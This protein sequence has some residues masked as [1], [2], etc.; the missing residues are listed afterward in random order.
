MYFCWIFYFPLSDDYGMEEADYHHMP[1]IAH[2]DN[3]ISS[4]DDSAIIK[5]EIFD[6][7]Y[8]EMHQM[9]V[10]SAGDYEQTFLNGVESSGLLDLKA[11]SD[12]SLTQEEITM[13]LKDSVMEEVPVETVEPELPEQSSTVSATTITTNS[14]HTI[15]NTTVDS[16]PTSALSSTA[17]G[18]SIQASLVNAP[19]ILPTLSQPLVNINNLNAATVLGSNAPVLTTPVFLAQGAPGPA[20]QTN[21]IITTHLA[22]LVPSPDG[23]GYILHLGLNPSAPTSTIPTA[24]TSCVSSSGQVSNNNNT[25]STSPTNVPMSG[26]ASA[27][28]MSPPQTC[29]TGGNHSAL[30]S[31]TST[32]DIHTTTAGVGAGQVKAPAKNS[33]PLGV[34][35]N[36]LNITITPATSS[37]AG[38]LQKISPTLKE[39]ESSLS[40]SSSTSANSSPDMGSPARIN[41]QVSPMQIVESKEGS[42]SPPIEEKLICANNTVITTSPPPPM[43]VVSQCINTVNSVEGSSAL[44][45]TTGAPLAINGNAT[46]IEMSA[47]A[48]L[49]DNSRQVL[50]QHLAA[51]QQQQQVQLI[52]QQPPR[53][54][55]KRRNSKELRELME[56]EQIA[57]KPG[58]DT[59]RFVICSDGPMNCAL[60]GYNTSSYSSFK[61]H[62]ICSHPCWRIT[63]KLSRN[64][65]LVEKSVKVSVPVAN[66]SVPNPVPAVPIQQ[67]VQSKKNKKDTNGK[68]T[69]EKAS[70]NDNDSTKREETGKS[71][72]NKQRKEATTCNYGNDISLDTQVVE[73][74]RRIYKCTRCL[75]LFVSEETTVNHIIDVH[76]VKKPYTCIEVSND[77]GKSFS[78]I[79]R[80]PQKNCSF[81]CESISG[82]EKHK[83]EVHTQQAVYR[84]QICGYSAD[85]TKAVNEHAVKIHRQQVMMYGLSD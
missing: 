21:S 56:L 64:R 70:K 2:M 57:S 52:Q 38:I 36:N 7:A 18:I 78:T 58:G 44:G 55:S 17:N 84:C 80:C 9:L 45:I 82:L 26:G 50:E 65:L 81:S 53:S 29:I 79:Y 43:A 59:D 33:L 25:A 32:T 68:E 73:G 6:P 31:T 76:N 60:C 4:H 51:Q 24:P 19:G 48:A 46:A 22:R 47:S 27:I 72:S 23:K 49:L 39:S 40:S 35:P 54:K 69:K 41:S 16:M 30:S 74:K 28:P 15:A 13:S 12:M 63:K 3:L 11:D 61:S 37:S 77:Y 75:K 10:S 34:S 66:F 67:R 42:E 62:I 8:D 1:N 85:S 20:G 5:S 83:N 71:G 14:T